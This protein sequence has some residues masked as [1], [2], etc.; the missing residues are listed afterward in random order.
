MDLEA[1]ATFLAAAETE[2][3]REAARRRYISQAA[4]SQ[5]VARLE[6]ELK[7]PLFERRGRRVRLAPGGRDFLPYAERLVR[8][9]EEARARLAVAQGRPRLVLGGDWLTAEAVIPWLCRHLLQSGD[10]LDIEVRPGDEPGDQ[11]DGAVL[12]DPPG[13]ARLRREWLM[14]DPVALVVP[15]DGA[16]W[17]REPPD[18]DTILRSTRLM[19]PQAAAYW[20]GLAAAL[21]DRGMVVPTVAL[22]Q[23]SAIR[24]L[25]HE[26]VGAAFLPRLAVTRD[27][28]EGRLLALDVP[29]LPPVAV[30]LYWVTP[31][32]GTPTAAVQQAERLLRR[33]WPARV[34][35]PESPPPASR[36]SP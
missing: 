21:A 24:R 33:R 25:I 35:R 11:W 20:P 3:F 7:T 30:S 26:G 2:N 1:V 17:D 9:A 4:V 10:P 29:W 36:Q 28:M 18:A 16:D 8:L 12:C 14:S 22:S 32:D 27:L 19:V 31:R 5:Q 13:S 15:A 34:R 23:L 6:A